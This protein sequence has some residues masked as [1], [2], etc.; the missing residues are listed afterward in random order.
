MVNRVV[1]A[2]AI[3]LIAGCSQ[4]SPQPRPVDNIMA[5]PESPTPEAAAEAKRNPNGWVYKI[6]GDYGRDDAVP[7]EA[8][9]GCWKVDEHGNI[10]GDF[11]PNPNFTPADQ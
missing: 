1:V 5:A 3:S 9:A 10:T 8:I 2:V 11:V 7:P 6:V 4:I